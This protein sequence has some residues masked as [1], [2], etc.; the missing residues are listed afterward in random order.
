MKEFKFNN[1]FLVNRSEKSFLI[2]IISEFVRGATRI[3]FSNNVYDIITLE[4]PDVE[5]SEVKEFTITRSEL[6][7]NTKEYEVKEKVILEEVDEAIVY[8]YNKIIA[9]DIINNKE[10]SCID[11]VLSS[12]LINSI[13]I[14]NL[15]SLGESIEKTLDISYGQ[16]NKITEEEKVD[17]SFINNMSTSYYLDHVGKI[18]GKMVNCSINKNVTVEEIKR[19]E[20][21]YKYASKLSLNI[22]L[23]RLVLA[24]EYARISRI[25]TSN[26]DYALTIY[27]K[28]LN[29]ILKAEKMFQVENTTKQNN[30]CNEI[31]LPELNKPLPMYGIL[32]QV[33]PVRT[34]DTIIHIPTTEENPNFVKIFTSIIPPQDYLYNIGSTFSSIVGCEIIRSSISKEEIDTYFNIYKED[35]IKKNDIF[36]N[37]FIFICVYLNLY[38]SKIDSA[39]AAD[40]VVG[41]YRILLNQI[42]EAEIKSVDDLREYRSKRNYE[43]TNKKFNDSD[44]DSQFNLLEQLKLRKRVISSIKSFVESNSVLKEDLSR[45]DSILYNKTN[46]PHKEYS[47]IVTY[48]EDKSISMVAINFTRHIGGSNNVESRNILFN[49]SNRNYKKEYTVNACNELNRGVRSFVI[50]PD[51]Q[52]CL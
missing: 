36:Y 9:R 43:M 48:S 1:S 42:I 31:D 50:E 39:K 38:K 46:E 10:A 52:Y 26:N 51:C 49:L 37:R 34:F 32:K 21:I 25:D 11:V 16:S 33:D 41:V 14:N 5:L 19:Y 12:R 15:E 22:S 6:N 40:I 8:F 18:F 17:D 28:L 44:L 20:D 27:H 35:I 7:V 3:T 24:C 30:L 45:Y 13:L 47:C 23:N 2:D 29:K 4:K